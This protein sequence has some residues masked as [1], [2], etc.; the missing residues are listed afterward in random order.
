MCFV[1]PQPQ[2]A[3]VVYVREQMDDRVHTQMLTAKTRVAPIKT[4]CVPRLELCAAFLGAQLSQAVKEAINDSRFP[5]PKV[6]AWTDSQVT[7]AWIKDIPRKWKTFVAKRVA[8]IQ[9]IIPSENWNFYQKKTIQPIAHHEEFQPT[10]LLITNFGG[11][12]PIGC[13][14]TS[15]FG[16]HWMLHLSVTPQLTL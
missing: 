3:A 10:N 15:S 6:F 2:T 1:T 13:V 7:L 14:K 9:S 8:K 12:D 11:K 16:L 5:N 4:L